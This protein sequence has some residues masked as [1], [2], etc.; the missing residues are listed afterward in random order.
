MP[1]LVKESKQTNSKPLLYISTDQKDTTLVEDWM[2]YGCELV[3]TYSKG[4]WETLEM[5]PRPDVRILCS[6]EGCRLTSLNNA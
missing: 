5:N 3:E 6:R 1:I 4:E 2:T